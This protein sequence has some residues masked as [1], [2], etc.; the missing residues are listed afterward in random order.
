M[1]YNN[2]N[3]I[4]KGVSVSL[5]KIRYLFLTGLFAGLLLLLSGCF[6]RG[7][8]ELYCVPKRSDAYLSL[9]E[10]VEAAIGDGEYCAPVSGENRQAI[11]Q[12]DLDGDEK[13]EYI[14]YARVGEEKPLKI[15]VF[16]SSG[17]SYKL[18]HTLEGDGSA[19]DSAYYVQVNGERGMELV[20]GRRVGDQVPQ[21][22][23]VYTF[24]NN[25]ATALVSTN[26]TD[27]SIRDVDEDGLSDLFVVR[28]DTELRNGVAELYRWHNGELSRDSEANLSVPAE[29]Y[30]RTTLGS[31]TDGTPA[32]FVAGAYDE[33][34]IIT[35]VIALQGGVFRNITLSDESGVS[36]STVRSYYAYSTD[37]DGDGTTEVPNTVLL[38]SVSSDTQTENQYIIIW[39]GL[40]SDGTRVEKKRTY[41]N[42]TDG[43]YLELPKEWTERLMVSRRVQGTSMGYVFYH[44]EPGG[45]ADRF[46]SIYAIKGEELPSGNEAGQGIVLATWNGVSYVAFADAGGPAYALDEQQLT[47]LFHSITAETAAADG[48]S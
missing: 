16:C 29:N 21:S 40:N 13:D 38:P 34:N 2:L 8:D 36:T 5:R 24:R 15:F 42:Y 43:W 23:T 11:Q 30:K 41:H 18:V 32:F 28:A 3:Y 12:A 19:F 37:I 44:V 48:V 26:Y 33:N 22:L 7:T 25:E 47:A 27:Y 10:A 6:M 1:C 45:K 9:Q 35:D 20:V 17:D 31:L 4:G 46:L 39:N 14:V